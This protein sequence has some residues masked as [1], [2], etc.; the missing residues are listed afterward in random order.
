[1]VFL[2]DSDL[3]LEDRL[4]GTAQGKARAQQEDGRS[5]CGPE[6]C[7][8]WQL[9]AVVPLVSTEVPCLAA[10][11]LADLWVDALVVV[12]RVGPGEDACRQGSGAL[13]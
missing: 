8:R 9:R 10:E 12:L 13:G 6:A 3:S 5:S 1:M 4:R 11:T 7:L 2:K